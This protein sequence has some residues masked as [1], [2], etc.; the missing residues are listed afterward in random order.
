M[1]NAAA[2]VAAL[3]RL[4]HTKKV[5][6]RRA[7]VEQQPWDIPFVAG[8]VMDLLSVAHSDSIEPYCVLAVLYP[9]SP[10]LTEPHR[11]FPAALHMLR[12][13]RPEPWR[14]T[15]EPEFKATLDADWD[16]LPRYLVRWIRRLSDAALPVYWESL[17]LDLCEWHSGNDGRLAVRRRWAQVVW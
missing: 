11:T 10:G 6:L 2:F 1:P 3:G 17:L 13:N 5:R 14:T 7:A 12:T 4:D 15:Y 9:W 16:Q 8:T